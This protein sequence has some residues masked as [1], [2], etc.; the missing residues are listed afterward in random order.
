MRLVRH[1][2][3]NWECAYLFDC[4]RVVAGESPVL[5]RN[6]IP[7]E[8]MVKLDYLYVTTWS[9]WRDLKLMVQTVPALARSGDA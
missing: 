7:F 4:H 1:H 6:H 3:G 5:G 2:V 8:E 9:L